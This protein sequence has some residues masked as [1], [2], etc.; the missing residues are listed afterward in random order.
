M[1]EN[2]IQWFLYLFCMQKIAEISRKYI[3]PDNESV[4]D[5]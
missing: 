1:K 3:Q 4:K 2:E 5:Y